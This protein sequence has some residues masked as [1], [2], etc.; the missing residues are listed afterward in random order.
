MQKNSSTWIIIANSNNAHICEKISGKESNL[1]PIYELEARST[2]DFICEKP[3]Q[4]SNGM[5]NG[6]H[7]MEPHSDPKEVERL[8]FARIISKLLN[9]A[10]SKNGFQKLIIIASPK[11]LGVL[12]K[13]LDKQI[14]DKLVLKLPKN[15]AGL[16][17]FDLEKYLSK[18]SIYLL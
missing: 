5:G 8:N 11:M 12:C 16:K 13:I 7:A 3:D 9:E 15:I 17:P 2:D 1:N 10:N 18:K 6:T 4:G 14:I